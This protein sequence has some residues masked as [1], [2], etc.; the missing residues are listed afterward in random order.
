MSPDPSGRVVPTDKGLP[1]WATGLSLAGFAGRR[2][3]LADAG[4]LYPVLTADETALAANIA[5]MAGYVREHGALLCPHGKTTM[6]PEV[7][8]RQLDAGAWGITAATV[9]QVRAFRSFGVGRVLLANEL[10]D[11]AGLDWLLAELDADPQFDCYAFVDSLAGVA[12]ARAA[13]DRRGPG[14]DLP[15]LVELGV[16]GKRTGCRTVDEAADVARAAGALEGIRLAGVAGYEGVLAATPGPAAEAAAEAA[17]RRYLGDL[18]SLLGSVADETPDGDLLVTAGGSVY[19]DLV[20]D[21]L[22]PAATGGRAQLV[23]RSGCYVTHDHGLY[24][25]TGPSARGSG[26]A[27]RPALRLWAQIGSVPEPG[28]ALAGF[29]R[30]DCSFDAGLPVPLHRLAGAGRGEPVPGVEVVGLNDQHAFLR[31]DGGLQVGDVLAFGISHPC[32]TLDKWRVIPVV[33]DT[34][35]VTDCLTTW[36]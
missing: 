4:F 19:F 10:V 2:P 11:P 28:L 7:I 13:L 12:A 24:A 26:P 1:A 9:S 21:E 29:G 17:V 34:L 14:R 27:L 36:F 25:T 32:T 30:R 15:L 23:L 8:R 22:G 16:P 18:R 31:H 5:A 3:N 6:S 33:D 20:A 35:T